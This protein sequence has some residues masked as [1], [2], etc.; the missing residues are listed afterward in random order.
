M[1]QLSHIRVVIFS[2]RLL[3]NRH[4]SAIMRSGLIVPS[5]AMYWL[6]TI[7]TAHLFSYS[8]CDFLLAFRFLGSVDFLSSGIQGGA[9]SQQ[10]LSGLGQGWLA[11]IGSLSAPVILVVFAIGSSIP[12]MLNAFAIFPISI[13]LATF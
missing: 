11:S 1:I 13:F 12:F 8:F 4:I 7:I 2:G 3:P 9:P 10:L 5:F 6:S